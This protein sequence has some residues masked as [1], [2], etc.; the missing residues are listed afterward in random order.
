MIIKYD[1]AIIV[2]FS[3]LRSYDCELLQYKYNRV[4]DFG[5]I[6]SGGFDKAGLL[7]S[8]LYYTE[9][10]GLPIER[11]MV[12]SAFKLQGCQSIY[13]EADIKSPMPGFE[14]YEGRTE[15]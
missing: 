10:G 8:F 11:P 14:I 15:S 1:S 5:S 13:G 2:I 3:I 4:S 7:V 12:S 6:I 9:I